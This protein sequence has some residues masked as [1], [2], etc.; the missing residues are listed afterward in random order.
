MEKQYFN[1]LRSTAPS[2]KIN[3]WLVRI[4]LDPQKTF[5]ITPA[6]VAVYLKDEVWTIS[7]FLDD[8]NHLD[9]RIP[10]SY[11]DDPG[12]E[13]DLA[14]CHVSSEYCREKHFDS[15]L[16]ISTNDSDLDPERETVDLFF[17][18]PVDGLGAW[19]GDS[20]I[21]VIEAVVYKVPFS[22]QSGVS[23]NGRLVEAV[24]VGFRGM[25]GAVALKRD[26]VET[27]RHCRRCL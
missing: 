25:S 18:E 19:A 15:F 6:H 10:K 23:Q 14:W 21:G 11:I 12:P 5:M 20:T 7:S 13:N 9:W 24:D 22:Q 17:R 16:D 1:F 3:A 26:G 27:Q 4:D 2:S 8:L